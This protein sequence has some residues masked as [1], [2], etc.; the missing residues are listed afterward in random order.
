MKKLIAIMLVIIVAL[1]IGSI[2][3]RKDAFPSKSEVKVEV[4]PEPNKELLGA[5]NAILD[6]YREMHELAVPPESR[7]KDY[8]IQQL[9][10]FAEEN[11]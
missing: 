4:N 9:R 10:K 2:V 5:A 1:A 8:L 11:P 7:P 6:S 3:L